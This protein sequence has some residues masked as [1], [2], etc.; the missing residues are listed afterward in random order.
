MP[1]YQFL[2]SNDIGSKVNTKKRKFNK[3][4]R[5]LIGNKLSIENVKSKKEDKM[6]TCFTGYSPFSNFRNCVNMKL[7]SGH[8]MKTNTSN[9]SL[10]FKKNIPHDNKVVKLINFV[11]KSVF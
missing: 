5:I 11:S 10:M 6:S 8:I 1:K 4:V 3:N 7:I 9:G 2:V